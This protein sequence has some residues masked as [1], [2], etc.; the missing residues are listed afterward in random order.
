M[1]WIVGGVSAADVGRLDDFA[2]NLDIPRKFIKKIHQS[3]IFDSSVE[4]DGDKESS[5]DVEQVADITPFDRD[6]RGVV[7]FVCGGGR[8]RLVGDGSGQQFAALGV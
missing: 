8:N 3:I 1:A 4:L 6:R 5:Q 2:I 7:G